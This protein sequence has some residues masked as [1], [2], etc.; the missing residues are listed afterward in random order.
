MAS[1]SRKKQYEQARLQM[2][3]VGLAMTWNRGG[4]AAAAEVAAEAGAGSAGDG[5]DAEIGSLT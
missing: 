3:P 2:A 4:A 1:L 5:R